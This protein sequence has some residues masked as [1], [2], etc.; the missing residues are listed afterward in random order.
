[1]RNAAADDEESRLLGNMEAMKNLGMV[2]YV[3]Y[4]LGI[5]CLH[6]PKPTDA[7]FPAMKYSRFPLRC[8]A[9]TSDQGVFNQIFVQRA[10]Q[11]LD[12]VASADLIVDCGANVGYSSAYFLSRFPGATVI[13]VEPDAQNF[14]ALEWNLQAL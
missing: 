7:I 2:G 12:D 10:C 9:G 1:M 3:R 5:R 6:A 13:A 4:K 8:R 14:A 11:C